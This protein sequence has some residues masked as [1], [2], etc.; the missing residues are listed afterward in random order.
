MMKYE[1]LNMD[2]VLFSAEDVID[3]SK[4]YI[5]PIPDGGDWM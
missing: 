4:D 1:E 3:P 5:P 2:V